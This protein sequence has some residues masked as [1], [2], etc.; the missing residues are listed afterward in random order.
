MTVACE[1]SL[2]AK[3]AA[4]VFGTV[5]LLAAGSAFVFLFDGDLPLWESVPI[6]GLNNDRYWLTID[7]KTVETDHVEGLKRRQLACLPGISG[8]PL[9]NPPKPKRDGCRILRLG[10]GFYILEVEGNIQTPWIRR[11]PR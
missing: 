2:K 8:V 10:L 4:A 7:G 11:L 3:R 9:S 6:Q 5:I 1:H